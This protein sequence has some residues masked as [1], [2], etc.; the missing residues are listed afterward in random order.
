[1]LLF[2]DPGATRLSIISQYP[3]GG[4]ENRDYRI[5]DAVQMTQSI[6]LFDS[7]LIKYQLID[8]LHQRCYLPYE[9]KIKSKTLGHLSVNLEIR[10]TP[11]IHHCKTDFKKI[12]NF[13]P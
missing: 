4:V 2:Q 10:I 12:C 7:R 3:L 13:N 5:C 9:R 6:H 11:M 1:M 8:K